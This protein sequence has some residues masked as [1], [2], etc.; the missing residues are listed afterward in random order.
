M[1]KTIDGLPAAAPVTAAALLELQ[2][3]VGVGSSQHCTVGEVLALARV[4]AIQSVASAATVTPASTDD[5][6][7][8]TA[9]AEALTLANPSGV[10]SPGQGFVVRIRDNGTARTIGFGTAYRALGVTL[11]TTTVISKLLYIGVI[12]NATDTKFDVVSVSKEA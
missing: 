12:Y 4:P 1:A 5:L 7:T 2:I 11:P 6:V 10:W 9:Q 8:V 3:G